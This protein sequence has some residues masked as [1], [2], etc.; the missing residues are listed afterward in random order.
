MKAG[1]TSPSTKLMPGKMASFS[2]SGWS[3]TRAW[4]WIITSTAS[5]RSQSNARMRVAFSVMKGPE[6]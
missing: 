6:A 5:P 2:R 1:A 3:S 4:H